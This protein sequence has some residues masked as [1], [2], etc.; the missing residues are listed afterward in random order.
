M[1]SSQIP[2]LC[3]KSVS[4]VQVRNPIAAA[5]FSLA[6]VRTGYPETALQNRDSA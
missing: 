3:E 2:M 5:D 4:V 6:G 1:A